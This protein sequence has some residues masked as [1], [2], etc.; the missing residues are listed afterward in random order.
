LK[1]VAVSVT[2]WWWHDHHCHHRRL[3]LWVARPYCRGL[4]ST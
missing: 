2:K 4:P 3:H 1:K